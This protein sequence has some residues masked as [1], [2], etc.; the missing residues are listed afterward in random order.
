MAKKYIAIFSIAIFLVAGSVLAGS[1]TTWIKGNVRYT[2][3]GNGVRI[4]LVDPSLKAPTA[5]KNI[6]QTPNSQPGAQSQFLDVASIASISDINVEYGTDLT[7]VNLPETVVATMSD[8]S[9][10][11][12]PVL[13]DDG[14]PKYDG[15]TAGTYVFSGTPVLSGKFTN[16]KSVKATVNVIVGSQSSTPTPAPA[17]TPTPTPTT[18]S[19]DSDCSSGQT[20]V[21]GSCAAPTPTP[22]LTTINITPLTASLTVGGTTQQL[23][24]ATLDQNG[25]TIAAELTWASDNTAVATVDANGLVT[26]VAEGTANITA[27]SNSITSTAPSVITVAVPSPSAGDIIQQATSSLLNGAGNFFNFIFSPFKKIF[28]IK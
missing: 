6:Q 26:P 10:K 15:N 23:S 28:N 7:S 14:T 4:S 1:P 11:T 9:A 25:T 18:C 17:P 2:R 12:S 22:V 20:C 19:S 5:N 24:A 16:T 13:W 8:K 27:T 3:V 21:S